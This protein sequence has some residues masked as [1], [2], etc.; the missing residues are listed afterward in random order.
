MNT[1]LDWAELLR[2]GF[3]RA[4]FAGEPVTFCVDREQLSS[5]SGL[6]ADPAVHSLTECVSNDVM[7]NFRFW[8]VAAASRR[9]QKDPV[10]P[11]PMLPLL[12]LNVLVA[13]EMTVGDQGGAPPFYKPLRAMLGGEPEGGLPGDYAESVPECWEILRWWLD[14]HLG[15]QR[16][17]STITIP[18]HFTNIGLRQEISLLGRREQR[19]HA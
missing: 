8:H 11:P 16:S 7:P 5:I 13:S 15:G 19:W 3:F 2:D 10:G 1:K 18:P 14:D 9:W 4:E 6:D 12:A 17:L